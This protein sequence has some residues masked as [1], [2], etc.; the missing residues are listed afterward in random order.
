MAETLRQLPF[1]VKLFSPAHGFSV[2][3]NLVNK[4]THFM[5]TTCSISLHSL[6]KLS[7]AQLHVMEIGDSFTEFLFYIRKH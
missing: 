2:L 1:T 5:Q 7:N 3:L 4:C 6:P